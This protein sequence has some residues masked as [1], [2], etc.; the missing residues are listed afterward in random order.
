M[1]HVSEARI[2]VEASPSEVYG[3]MTDYARWPQIFSDVRSVAIER[4]GRDDARVRFRSRL[5]RYEVT[6]QFHNEPGHRIAFEGVTGPP[7]GRASGW[8]VLAAIDGGHRTEV[9]ASL[10]L[11]LVGVPRLLIG[12]A[13]VRAVR[14]AKLAIDL[15][16]AARAFVTRGSRAVQ[17]AG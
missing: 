7:G 17:P 15:A 2:T 14:E 6:V 3:V 12:E 1:E 10:H 11:E 13:R 4:G 9:H 8:Y 16:D 5:L